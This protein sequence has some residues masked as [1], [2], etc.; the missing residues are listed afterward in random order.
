MPI[1]RSK[2]QSQVIYNTVANPGSATV[3]ATGWYESTE[4]P[5]VA[6]AYLRNN[7]IVQLAPPLYGTAGNKSRSCDHPDQHYWLRYHGDLTPTANAAVKATIDR[8]GLENIISVDIDCKLLPCSTGHNC[9]VYAVPAFMAAKHGLKSIPLRIFSH[10][11]EQLGG[12]GTGHT[13]SKRVIL[14]NTGQTQP[15]LMNAYNHH[16]GWGWV[17]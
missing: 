10:A 3:R 1:N 16:D 5:Y 11:N 4:I 7:T 12:G 14:C 17:P 6:H 15:D 8:V 2:N 13:S 9:C